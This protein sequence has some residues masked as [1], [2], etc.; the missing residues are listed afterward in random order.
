[1]SRQYTVTVPLRTSGLDD[2][3]AVLAL[4]KALAANSVSVPREPSLSRPLDV[5]AGHEGPVTAYLE[6]HADTKAE[7]ERCTA[8]VL[9]TLGSQGIVAVGPLTIVSVSV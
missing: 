4:Q 9:S 7:V 3:A 8:A 2:A 1:M 5:P 6:L